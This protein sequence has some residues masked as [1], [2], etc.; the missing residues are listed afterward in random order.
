MAKNTDNSSKPLTYKDY[1]AMD[2]L[3]LVSYIE[4]WRQTADFQEITSDNVGIAANELRRLACN[5]S[6]LTSLSAY[7]RIAKR[8]L[9]GNP[10]NKELY[11]EM[12]DKEA[13]I[14]DGMKAL[15]LNYRA[16][17][18]SLTIYS[19]S[20]NELRMTGGM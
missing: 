15:D 17:N 2:S 7:A 8:N 5:Y 1:L 14:A 13:I 19:D 20:M 9:K 16:L 6:F 10:E 12:I 4:S 11:G 3:S 18:K